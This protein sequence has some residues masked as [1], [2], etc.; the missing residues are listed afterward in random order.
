MTG[1]ADRGFEWRGETSAPLARALGSF[2]SRNEGREGGTHG[3][4]HPALADWDSDP[5][6]P[7]A[8]DLRLSALIR[9]GTR[10]RVRSTASG[11]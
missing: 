8:L 10:I 3:K 5:H 9:L 7:S 2:A 4:R 6:H 11:P 1:S